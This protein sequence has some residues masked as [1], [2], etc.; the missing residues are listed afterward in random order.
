MVFLYRGKAL[1]SLMA[2]EA[3]QF[4]QYVRSTRKYQERPWKAQRMA[5]SVVPGREKE[6]RLEGTYAHTHKRHC[7]KKPSGPCQPDCILFSLLGLRES[8]E[9]KG[10]GV[11]SGNPELLR[12][13]SNCFHSSSK[14]L[15]SPKFPGLPI[16]AL[17]CLR[18]LPKMTSKPTESQTLVPSLSE[19]RPGGPWTQVISET[20]LSSLAAT[21][22]PELGT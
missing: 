12:S 8:C 5:A 2:L 9:C 14:G 1:A 22:Q 13:P 21:S 15:Y 16:M 11:K 18:E 4:C 3:I 6:V 7:R 19:L 17:Y 10:G 20:H